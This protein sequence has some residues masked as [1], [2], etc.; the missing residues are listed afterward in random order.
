MESEKA[1]ETLIA[2]ERR[3]QAGG[4]DRRTPFEYQGTGR[5]GEIPGA[6]TAALI[7][8]RRCGGS[9]GTVDLL[10]LRGLLLAAAGEMAVFDRPGIRRRVVVQF[11]DTPAGMSV[12]DERK[13]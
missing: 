11:F 8:D 6:Q 1:V 7:D 4:P 3:R 2:H 5:R 12:S 10:E 9:D 13:S